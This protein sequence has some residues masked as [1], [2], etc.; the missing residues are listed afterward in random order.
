[1][2][3]GT[4]S[5]S[6][7]LATLFV[8]VLA[9]SCR[10]AEPTVDAALGA[11]AYRQPGQ[12]VLPVSDKMI[13]AEAE[14]FE[15]KQPGWEAKNWGTNYYCASFANS[16]LSRQAYLGAPEQCEQSLAS[17]QVTV[18]AD[19][20]YLALVRY[21]AAFRFETQFR[22][23]ILQNGKALLDRPYG[24]LDNVKIW[25]FRQKLKKQVEWGWGACENLVW[26]GHDAYVDLKK[27]KAT[28]ELIADK[29][30]APAARR[31]VDVVMLTT[32]EQDVK[33]RIEKENYLP[34]DGLL[35][36]A[37]DV[38]LKLHNQP[39]G[40]AMVLAVPKGTEH[41][42]YWVHMRTWKTKTLKA[43]PGQSTGWEEVGGLLDS[44][45]S[46]QWTLSARPAEKGAPL[47][48]RVEIGVRNAAGG[49]E[50]IAAF[51]SRTGALALFYDGNTRYT[52]RV[53]P[54]TFAL[55][56]LVDY[57]KDRPV[58][59]RPPRRT[60]IYCYTFAPI[61]GDNK[62]NAARAELITM[63]GFNGLA[64][65]Q[66][67]VNLKVDVPTGY[68]DVRRK[69]LKDVEEF[70]K[71]LQAEGK[72][73]SMGVVS[74]GDE[75]GLARPPA[76][77][78]EA[79]RAWLKARGMKPSDVDPAAGDWAKINYSPGGQTATANP[80]VYY[81]SRRYMHHY[82]IQGQKVVTNVLARYL[83]NAGI[84]ANYSPHHAHHYLG[85]V[86]MWVTMF[87]EGAMTMPWS[88]DY[89]WQVPVCS[90]QVNFINLD[91][92][93]A[94]LKGKPE[95]KIHYYVMAHTPGNTA[96][97]WRRQF[98]GDLAHGMKIVNLFEID[99]LAA[100]YTENYVEY[101]WMYQT[102]RT[103]FHELGLFEDFVQDGQVRA[104][105]AGLW[106][107]ETGDIW[108]DN[109]DPFSAG[110]RTLYCSI[111][112]QQLQ[113]DFVVEED[114][115]A[116]DLKPYKVLYLADRHVSRAAA[117]AI[118]DW[119]ARGGTLFATAGAGMLDELNRPNA[120]MH[121][122]LGVAQT[123]LE[124]PPGVRVKFTKQ[125]IQFAQPI[126]TVTCNLPGG[127]HTMPVFAVRSRVKLNGARALG[128]FKD[129]SPA[130]TERAVGKGRAFYCAFLPGLTYY[131]PAVPFR[132]VDRGADEDAMTHFI[133]TEFDPAASRL[134][135]LPAQGVTRPVVCSEPLVESAIIDS[136]HG[137]LIPLM[138]W[139]A[140]PVK[141][142]DVAVLAGAKAMDASLASGRPLQGPVVR[143]AGVL[144][145]TLD[146]DV[147]DAL[148]L[149]PK[150]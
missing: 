80:G 88:E 135:A 93:R 130:L 128:T 54:V 100:A 55:Y 12:A 73:K 71:K 33:N 123:A 5:P 144:H 11:Q 49:I 106:F 103:A 149:K 142:L 105:N 145:F 134:I 129:G 90:P 18:P 19:G 74:L 86:H 122:L 150:R 28:I 52:R 87:R 27:G 126:D 140:G 6:A 40:S 50:S 82:G 108:D 99:R 16:F 76:N 61:Q 117:K 31:N 85:E 36:Q 110:K 24:A 47:H 112:H 66:I 127:T 75:I 69:S 58:R 78:H 34:L 9:A 98:Y 23:R 94:G 91:L 53:R 132:P 102:V 45:N 116:G 120:P 26:E 37:G 92:F 115:L 148:I 51:E 21:E 81:W 137:L 15:I 48:Y 65:G 97:D 133:P 20:R 35:T 41:S 125:D 146:L 124:K 42:P 119:V 111:L 56:E 101:P 7:L 84:G 77:S 141:G 14:E 32:D 10:S 17:I 121:D 147:A 29:Q 13:L 2:T 96:S 72:A 25:A 1:M 67:G 43:D 44:L 4:H 107:S 22:M 118:A 143:E 95:A 138:N 136:K 114:A 46:G 89:I 68:T 62:Y 30:P 109:S 38:Y 63:M 57:L 104:G 139:S 3:R 60:P 83:P 8:L 131:K 113:L 79:F 59:G 39:G 64:H 70:C